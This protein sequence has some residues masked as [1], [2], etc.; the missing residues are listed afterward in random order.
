MKI[1]AR[2]KLKGKVVNIKEGITTVQVNVELAS[3][4]IVSG[5]ITKESFE[6][7]AIQ[8]NEEI[9]ALIKSTD[10]MFIK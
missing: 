10:V 2:N 5:V 9:T 7:M 4:E 8:K 6:D 3:G 1:S